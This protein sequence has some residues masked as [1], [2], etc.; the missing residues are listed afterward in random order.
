MEYP[1]CWRIVI[2]NTKFRVNQLYGIR[3]RKVVVQS[4]R[5]EIKYNKEA[6]FFEIK[7]N[8]PDLFREIYT[9]L[10]HIQRAICIIASNIH[11][12]YKE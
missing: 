10:D 9:K 2:Q 6:F 11:W 7:T 8:P 5:A 12:L 4:S 3:C 1:F